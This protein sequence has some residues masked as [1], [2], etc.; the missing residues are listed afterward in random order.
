M[1]DHYYGTARQNVNETLV[2]GI[3]VILEIDWQGAQQVKKQ[4]PGCCG[5]FI[6]PPS[7]QVLLERLTARGQ[8]DGTIIARRMQD[9]VSEMSHY[10]EFDYLVINDKFDEA[11]THLQAIIVARRL[12][13]QVQTQRQDRLLQQLLQ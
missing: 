3:D 13:I 5:I 8:D 9:A 6:L 4:Y 7:R 12:S 1:F 11:L 10:H 2:K